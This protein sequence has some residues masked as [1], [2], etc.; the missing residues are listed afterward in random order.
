[1]ISFPKMFFDNFYKNIPWRY[2]PIIVYMFSCKTK[3]HTS[4]QLKRLVS[5]VLYK[6]T[7]LLLYCT[8]DRTLISSRLSN[9]LNIY[10]MILQSLVPAC[11]MWEFALHWTKQVIFK[12]VTFVFSDTFLWLHCILVCWGHC[13]ISLSNFNFSL[14]DCWWSL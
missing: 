13:F 9:C 11:Q 2:T 3:T 7:A 14:Y 6:T 12:D 10:F 5:F 4:L 8:N 1:M